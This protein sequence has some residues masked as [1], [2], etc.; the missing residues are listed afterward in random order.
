LKNDLRHSLRSLA[1]EA[2]DGWDL[3]V[4]LTM[5]QQDGATSLDQFEAEKN[6]RHFLNRL[7]KAA[8]GNA[9]SRFGKKVQALPILER[10]FGGRWHY[11]LAME[12]PF[13]DLC[14][15]KDSIIDCWSKTR[16]GYDQVD[17]QPIFDAPGW[18][19]YITKNQSTDGWDI[20][21]THLVR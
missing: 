21:N 10:T 7:N 19:R 11:H 9:A 16:W 14:V 18:V 6:L 1:F 12:D 2:V 8:F 20:M 4:T 13:A 3:A 15:C 5:K 17:V